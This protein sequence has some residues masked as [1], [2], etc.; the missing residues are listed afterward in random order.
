MGLS[1]A[2]IHDILVAF[3]GV[4]SAEL[5]KLGGGS[6][7]AGVVQECCRSGAGACQERQNETWASDTGQ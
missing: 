6:G 5:A 3:G 2:G 1:D 7:G 4:T